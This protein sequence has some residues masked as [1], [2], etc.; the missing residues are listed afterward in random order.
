MTKIKICGITNWDDARQAIDLG[1]DFLGFIFAPS[2]RR[3]A[4]Q[5]ARDIVRRLP[6]GLETVGVVRDLSVDAV[7][8]LQG[9][10]GF[11]WVQLHGAEPPE[12]AKRFYPRV[13]KAFSRYRH[14]AASFRPYAGAVLLLDQPKRFRTGSTHSRSRSGRA[15][16]AVSEAFLRLARQARHYGKVILAGGL[17][18]ENVAEWVRRLRPWGVDVA[19]GV[20]SHPG[21]KD[22]ARLRA[23]FEAVRAAR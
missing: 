20:E 18:P 11:A 1:A 15:V 3:V 16:S 22:P 19:R 7:Q 10:V 12:M 2:P 17:E 8:A 4:P 9:G 23:F 14:G 5:T 13:I 21:K 6:H